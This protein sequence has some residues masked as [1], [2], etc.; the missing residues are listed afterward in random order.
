VCFVSSGPGTRIPMN[1][2]TVRRPAIERARKDNS[3][4]PGDCTQLLLVNGQ[5]LH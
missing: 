4:A 1:A 5:L 3:D 2:V